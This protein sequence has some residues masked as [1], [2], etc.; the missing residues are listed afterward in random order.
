M[1]HRS[2]CIVNLRTSVGVS[3]RLCM[4][5]S[6]RAG[7]RLQP[8]GAQKYLFPTQCYVV[9][10]FFTA[11]G[12]P[13][14]IWRPPQICRLPGSPVPDTATECSKCAFMLRGVS[15]NAP[16]KLTMV[17]KIH[18]ENDRTSEDPSLSGNWALF[19]P[20]CPVVVFKI[21]L[22]SAITKTMSLLKF[23]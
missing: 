23:R 17:R 19:C 1:S 18:R 10:F 2:V 21:L 13:H 16:K 9:F 4:A 15:G 12:A 22:R 11:R 6:Q 7:V 3:I 20:P 5:P 8:E 14:V